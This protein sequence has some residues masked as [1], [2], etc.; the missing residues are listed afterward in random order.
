MTKIGSDDNYPYAELLCVSTLWL[1]IVVDAVLVRRGLD[2]SHGHGHKEHEPSPRMNGGHGGHGH[3]NGG[4]A[5][6][7]K[8]HMPKPFSEGGHSHIIPQVPDG[9]F[10]D[11]ADSGNGNSGPGKYAVVL[12]PMPSVASKSNASA[13][14]FGALPV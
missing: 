3:G 2:G 12:Q 13:W 1:L 11:V 9:Y 8:N 4:H 10:D 5:H 7:G 14:A 6:G